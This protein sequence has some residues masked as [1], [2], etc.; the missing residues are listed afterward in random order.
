MTEPHTNETITIT[1]A[2]ARERLARWYAV[3]HYSP[4]WDGLDEDER[5][6]CYN[7]ASSILGALGVSDG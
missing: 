6:G 7:F 2:D 5:W 4:N 3:Q 1:I